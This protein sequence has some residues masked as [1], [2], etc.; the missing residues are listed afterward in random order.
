MPKH[1]PCW[2]RLVR[3]AA[4]LALVL[5][6]AL[7][8]PLAQRSE[9]EAARS[10]SGGLLEFTDG[11][12]LHGRMA[13]I[14]PATGLQ[15][16]HDASAQPLRLGPK[17]L[18]NIQFNTATAPLP[19]FLPTARFYF[20]NGDEILGN[21]DSMTT[22]DASI[23]SWFGGSLQC[24]RSSLGAVLLSNKGYRLLYEGPGN[25]EGWRTGRNPKSWQLKDLGFEAQAADLL[26]RDFGLKG[27]SVI[28]FDLAWAGTFSM[29]IT[30]YA[31][32]IDR[33]DYSTSAYVM[34]LGSA[35]ISLQRVQ[36]G[37]GASLLGQVQLP[38]FI[39]NRRARIEIRCNREEGTI[40]LVIDGAVVQRWRD[41]A[42]WVANGP[43]LV[44]FSQVEPRGLRISNI[45]VAEWD[46]RFDAE[47][48][49]TAPKEL[50]VLLLANRDKVFGRIE[51]IEEGKIHIESRQTKL[52]VP[53]Q[54]VNY[55]RFREDDPTPD[56]A[57]TPW[58]VRAAFPGGE[59]ISFQLSK[60]EE[61]FVTGSSPLFG[62]VSFKAGLVRSL[63]FNLD[64]PDPT[65]AQG[66]GLDEFFSG[67]E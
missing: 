42:G 48:L 54:R 44:F 26:G 55:I 30:L 21:L 39:R 10:V 66:V 64:Q 13:S 6:S 3:L 7:P 47:M 15:W 65:S 11:S 49:S 20:R 46:G 35:A 36:A 53:M 41:N 67:F 60:W 23:T 34:Y 16:R 51:K 43:G 58:L 28:E 57:K 12:I 45:R 38:D 32:V 19:E 5:G 25:T 18:S 61:G 56:P 17:H 37:A 24:R 1:P 2:K 8:P 59:G 52:T 29:S 40:T 4:A 27:S 31:Q 62:E 22:S 63:R 9:P 50:D 14:D 33:F